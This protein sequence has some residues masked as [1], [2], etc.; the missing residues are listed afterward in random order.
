[1]DEDFTNYIDFDHIPAFIPFISEYAE[2]QKEVLRIGQPCVGSTEE[3]QKKRG[4]TNCD[5]CPI[6]KFYKESEARLERTLKECVSRL[7]RKDG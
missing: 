1:M 2:I 7:A 6:Y 5:D 4:V 3:C